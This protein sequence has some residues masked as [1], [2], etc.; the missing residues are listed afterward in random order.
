MPSYKAQ[1][2]VDDRWKIVAYVRA[3]QRSQSATKKDVPENVLSEI[4]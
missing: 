1:V 4:K 2:P 3:L